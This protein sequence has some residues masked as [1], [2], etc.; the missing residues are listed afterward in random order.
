V[1]RKLSHMSEELEK[2]NKTSS[3]HLQDLH[4]R[5]ENFSHEE[6]EKDK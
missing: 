2:E 3:K 4:D 1:V 5:G 6:Q